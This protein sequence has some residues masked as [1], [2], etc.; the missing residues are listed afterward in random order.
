MRTQTTT[1]GTS[2]I[3]SGSVLTFTFR[4]SAKTKKSGGSQDSL[5]TIG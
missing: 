3:T 2:P 5:A 4:I 1:V